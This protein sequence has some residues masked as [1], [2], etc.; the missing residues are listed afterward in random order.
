MLKEKKSSSKKA[1]PKGEQHEHNHEHHHHSDRELL[2]LI[3]EQ[4]LQILKN[5]ETMLNLTNITT[6][7]TDLQAAAS[8]IPANNDVAN[9][10]AIDALAVQ[11]EAVA[12]TLKGLATPPTA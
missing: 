4:N 3:F 5:Q 9:Q 12:T 2:E 8:A 11:I 10:A 1:Q 6:A 7:V